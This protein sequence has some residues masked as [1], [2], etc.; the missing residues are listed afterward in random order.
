MSFVKN[1]SFLIK[2]NLINFTSIRLKKTN[3]Q[4]KQITDYISLLS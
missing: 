1:Y 4:L 3:Y 2:I